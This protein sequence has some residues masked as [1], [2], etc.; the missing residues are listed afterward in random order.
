MEWQW[1]PYTLPVLVAA[2]LSAALSFLAWRRRPSPGAA[3]VALLMAAVT[4]WSVGY[5]LELSSATFG[6]ELF[7]SAAQYLGIVLIPVAW[8]L[9]ALE[10]SGRTRTSARRDI[11]ILGIEP[12]LVLVLVLANSAH[13]LVWRTVGSVGTGG[14]NAL[15][16]TYG[17]VFWIHMA[18]SYVLLLLGAALLAGCLLRSPRLYRGQCA[19]ALTAAAVPGAG[20]IL[21]VT[22]FNPF[23]G[24]DFAPFAFALSGM[25]LVFG[26]YRY[27]FLD[28]VP[29]ARHVLIEEMSDG[30]V[31]LDSASR[32]VDM[33]P[34]AQHLLGQRS[35]DVVGKP[36][37]A[38]FA[39]VPEADRSRMATTPD[40]IGLELT[41]GLDRRQVEFRVRPLGWRRTRQGGSLII[42]RDVTDHRTMVEEL[43]RANDRLVAAQR[44]LEIQART[45]PLTGAMNRRAILER[46]HQ[47]LSRARRESTPLSLAMLDIDQFKCVNDSYGHHVGDE[48]LRELV[49]RL[50][51]FLRPYDGLGRVGGEE[52]LIV[53]PGVD[54]LAAD[55]FLERVCLEVSSRPFQ[56]EERQLWITVSLGGATSHAEPA[57]VL[58]R[59]ADDALYRAKAA[60]RNCCATRTRVIEHGAILTLDGPA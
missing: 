8:L 19:A 48:I 20:S 54:E 39:R 45:D 60:G 21:Y 35:F 33:N 30:V 59:L 3:W 44:I 51:L 47:E 43:R 22:G 13:H 23:R 24:L 37:E 29:V 58:Y 9:F 42:V 38:A 32:V 36:M 53:A 12:V 40:D 10:Y 6:W 5:C 41:V 31:V 57:E 25:C 15:V 14:F 55:D 56:V 52:F 17:A 16:R 49:G 4:W 11:V 26:V 46:L 1:T 7:W 18:Y 28:M 34:A 50:L 27:R 2:A